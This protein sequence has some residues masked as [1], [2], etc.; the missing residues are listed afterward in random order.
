[1]VKGTLL[2]ESLQIGAEV[3]VAGLRLKRVSRRDVSASVSAA[4]PP[5]WTFLEFEANDDVARRLADSLAGALL[6]D[7]GWYA[8]FEAGSDHVVVFAGKIFRYRRGDQRGRSEAMNYGRTMGVPEHQLD[9][10]D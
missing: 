5:V 3:D 10:P 8:D 4:Q 2:A 6:A 9:W 7:G 1:M